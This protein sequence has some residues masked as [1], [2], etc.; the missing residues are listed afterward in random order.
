ML[1]FSIMVFRLHLHSLLIEGPLCPSQ[2]AS[3]RG[4]T[5]WMTE[6]AVGEREMRKGEG[7][8]VG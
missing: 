1:T 4:C 8:V 2:R 5:P 6:L 7:K 3:K